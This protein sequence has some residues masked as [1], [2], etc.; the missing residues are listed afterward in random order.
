M[1]EYEKGLATSDV[2]PGTPVII[3]PWPALMVARDAADYCGFCGKNPEQAFRAAVRR[4]L[5]PKP[6]QKDGEQQKWRRSDLDRV[7]EGPS[8]TLPD[9]WDVE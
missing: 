8:D 7:I 6:R 5:Y 2:A 1:A 3:R 9:G 4:G